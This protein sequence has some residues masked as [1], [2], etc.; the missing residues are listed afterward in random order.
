MEKN[1]ILLK[2]QKE[3]KGQDI[4]DLEAQKKGTSIAF[5]VG[6][7][8]FIAIIVVEMIVNNVM[9][10]EIMGGC[11]LM[12]AT[13]FYVKFLAFYVKFFILKKRHELVVAICYTLIAIGWLTFWVLRL[14]KVI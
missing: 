9:H 7:L 11:F 8:A 4:A 3:N 5:M 10:Y 12:L 6:G 1:E 2:A 14:T 13:A